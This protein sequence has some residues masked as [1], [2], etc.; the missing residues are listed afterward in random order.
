MGVVVTKQ[1]SQ[2][3]EKLET[4]LIS[5]QDAVFALFNPMGFQTL[6]LKYGDDVPVREVQDA[7]ARAED[8]LCGGLAVAPAPDGV[9]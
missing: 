5:T 6:L 4:P 9:H 2:V 3:D 8:W 7:Y 1:C